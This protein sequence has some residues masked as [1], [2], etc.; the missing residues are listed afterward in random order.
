MF[1]VG[2]TLIGGDQK[3][4]EER[5]RRIEG[6]CQSFVLSPVICIFTKDSPLFD[7]RERLET[8]CSH[9]IHSPLS[10]ARET[11][12]KAYHQ[13]NVRGS[14]LIVIKSRWRKSRGGMRSCLCNPVQSRRTCTSLFPLPSWRGC[15]GRKRKRGKSRWVSSATVCFII[16]IVAVR[17][18]VAETE[19]MQSLVGRTNNQSQTTGTRTKIQT[20]RYTEREW[21]ER[22]EVRGS[23]AAR[24]E[25][26]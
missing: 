8:E 18:V 13:N 24:N 20:G 11:K 4:G 16:V 21:R 6:T 19:E 15:W 5:E 12:R 1:C 25:K 23:D 17:A 26:K 3:P 7:G 14:S 2:E 22:C 10:E 9:F